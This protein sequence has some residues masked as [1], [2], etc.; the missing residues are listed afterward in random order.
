MSGLQ[1]VQR[2]DARKLGG[3]QHRTLRGNGVSRTDCRRFNTWQLCILRLDAS[4][5]CRCG[6]CSLFSVRRCP[7]RQLQ[8]H[9]E[10]KHGGSFIVSRWR[11]NTSAR[12]T[13]SAHYS[14]AHEADR[15][16]LLLR[17]ASD[18]EDLSPLLFTCN[19]I[20]V[21]PFQRYSEAGYFCRVTNSI[22]NS[23]LILLEAVSNYKGK[24]QS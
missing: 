1:L 13:G 6:R 21:M 8:S 22:V 5:C 23:A 12:P 11:D 19:S 18:D 7:S 15:L 16:P 17:T 10:N 24:D 4:Y 3:K 2:L 14:S 9:N 20:S